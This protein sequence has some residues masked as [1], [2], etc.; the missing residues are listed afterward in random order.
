MARNDFLPAIITRFN[1]WT[2]EIASP[3]PLPLLAP[4]FQRLADYPK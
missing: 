2:F 4:T 3:K 1:Y